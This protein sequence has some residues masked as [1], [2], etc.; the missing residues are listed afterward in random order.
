MPAAVTSESI[1]EVLPEKL[2]SEKVITAAS[3]TLPP[4]LGSKQIPLEPGNVWKIGRSDVNDIVIADSSVSRNHAIIQRQADGYYLIDMGS[5]NG[6]FVNGSRV[7][8]P[9]VLEDG[10]VLLFGE[11]EL[12]FEQKTANVAVETDETIDG[13]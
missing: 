11:H 13:E 12:S 2:V 10:D 6:C 7:S 1:M 8:I 3:I 9:I 5:R 4:Q